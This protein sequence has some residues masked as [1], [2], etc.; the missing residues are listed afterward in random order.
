MKP[1]HEEFETIAQFSGI[2][3]SFGYVILFG[4]VLPIVAFMAMIEIFFIYRRDSFRL[5]N[6]FR[7][8]VTKPVTDIGIWTSLFDFMFLLAVI[9]SHM[10][11]F[12]CTGIYFCVC[13]RMDS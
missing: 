10:D 8:I 1:Y 7:R 11:L 2:F 4:C 3:F 5:I 6:V 9:V 13:R 12:V